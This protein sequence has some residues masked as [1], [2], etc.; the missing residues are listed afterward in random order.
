MHVFIHLCTFFVENFCDRHVAKTRAGLTLH[1]RGCS[2]KVSYVCEVDG[3][4]YTTANK[5]I[6]GRHSGIHEAEALFQCPLCDFQTRQLG[7]LNVHVKTH[8]Q[9]PMTY[10]CPVCE[11]GTNRKCDFDKH[12]LIHT[13][14]R[15]YICELCSSTFTTSSNLA[16]HKHKHFDVNSKL[17]IKT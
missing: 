2:K 8:T 10:V 6:M 3:C 1:G 4:G 11:Y 12:T 15:P 13:G 9:G 14:A 16:K 5:A 7:N 17:F